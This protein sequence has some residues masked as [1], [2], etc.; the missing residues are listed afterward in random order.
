MKRFRHDIA[1]HTNGGVYLNFIGGEGQ[2]R[3][4]A[5]YGDANYRRL[6]AVKGEYD[7][8]NTF[9]GNQNIEPA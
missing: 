2:D 6:A 7:P 5:A 1:P 9:R 3:V 8:N 4:R